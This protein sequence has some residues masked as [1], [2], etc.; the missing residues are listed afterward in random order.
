[1]EF[2]RLAF[3]PEGE[4]LRNA[5]IGGVLAGVAFGIIGSYVVVR[6][7]SYI[8]GAISHC[9]LGGIGASLFFQG[10]YGITWFPPLLGAIFA[11]LLAAVI[12]GLVSIYAKERSDT[13][14]SAIWVVGMA[15]GI[16]LFNKTPGYNDLMSYLFGNILLIST[17]DVVMILVLDV[18]IVIVAILFY[19]KL[20]ALSFDE[21]FAQLRGVRAGMF[22]ILLLCAVALTV[23]F[24]V[25][26][27]GI[28]MVIAL[29]TLPAAAAGRYAKKLWQM[30]ILATLI[31]IFCVTGGFALSYEPD[32]P[33]GAVI[34]I[35]AGMVYLL[36]M[37][38]STV[39]R[40][41]T[42]NT[43]MLKKE[44]R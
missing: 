29:L 12:I 38:S 32:L 30:M 36:A 7:I 2:F 16:V 13:I 27:V 8:A 21:E 31:A 20:L 39:L 41:K 24:M 22:Y 34:V 9:I 5:L 1:M 43:V 10:N 23:V 11:A 26:I 15:I 25:R 3:S 14:I 18:L 17:N 33:S 35:L 42:C 40:R 4:F 44:K 28:V 6:R 37:V 19:N